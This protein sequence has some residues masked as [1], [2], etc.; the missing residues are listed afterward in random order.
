MQRVAVSATGFEAATRRSVPTAGAAPLRID[1]LRTG[2]IAGHVRD[3]AG[4]AVASA[5]IVLAGSGV[6]PARQV[7]A[8][9]DGAY[10]IEGVPGGVYEVRAH[11]GELVADPREGLML[12][13]GARIDVDLVLLPGLTLS[14]VVMDA[15]G[16]AP[17]ASVEVL[18]T[19]DA[20]SFSPRA[21]RT[22]VQGAF[23][24]SGLRDRDH[25]RVGARGRIRRAHRQHRPGLTPVRIDLRRAATI[26]GIVVDS[27]GAPVRGAQVEITGTTDSG[28]AAMLSGG[29]LAFQSALFEAQL[30]G[31]TPLRQNGELGVT[32]G[33]VPPIPLVPS[34]SGVASAVGDF[35][36]GFGTDPDGHFRITG[37]PPGRI[38]LTARH[39]AYAP[40]EIPTRIVTAGAVIDDVRIVLPDGGVI[41]GRVVD[42]RG[43][44][45]ATVRVE[46]TGEHEPYPRG[47]LAGSDGTFEFRGVLGALTVTAYPV[48]QPPARVHVEIAAGQTLPVSVPL[49]SN[50]VRFFGRV[51]DSR[52]FPVPYAQV[53]VRSLR[54]RTP[55]TQTS[56][57]SEDGTFVFES[58]P[59]PP[60]QLEVDHPD[61][62]VT[63]IARVASV[64]RELS[65]HLVAG[66]LVRGT[67]SDAPARAPLALAHVHLESPENVFDAVTNVDGAYEMSRVP[68]A[69][70][71]LSVEADAHVAMSRAVRVSVRRDDTEVTLDDVALDAGG[72]VS[73]D[74]VDRYGELVSGA[75]VVVGEPLD[76]SRAVRTDPH[77]HF[78]VPGVPAG[79]AILYA[80][81]PAAGTT[82]SATRVRVFAAEESPGTVLRLPERFDPSRAVVEDA[83][84][85]SIAAVLRDTP[86]GVTVR[87]V[88]RGS[89]AEAAGLRAGDTITSVDEVD[90][91]RSRDATTRLRG[92]EGEDVVVDVKRGER[93]VRLVIARER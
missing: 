11:Q 6:W 9:A 90:V 14:G 52:D 66:V 25:F 43:Y 15:D 75:D 27:R 46:L 68:L 55:L 41:D 36:T 72:S 71:T 24:V 50:V 5:T 30:A 45:V 32:S 91:Q 80:R 12:D 93:S 77:G 54:A 81:H 82:E 1:L 18:V 44:P 62:A 48:G 10:H 60:Y 28:A 61:Y 39:L 23:A 86:D 78:I 89:R 19:E 63:R 85:A 58:L 47:L 59:E 49:E 34:V 29:A 87:S 4:N 64:E 92:T 79:D 74:V 7:H 40:A 65:V 33:G 42:A 69:D 26:S 16:N 83:P 3:A 88:R 37:V 31:P 73:G 8:G 56:D 76:W 17:L 84:R 2:V 21:V 20:L 53:R 22:N 38:Q 57:S 13:P 51:L 67:V 70:Y 35:T